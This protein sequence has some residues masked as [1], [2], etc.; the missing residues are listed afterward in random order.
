MMQLPVLPIDGRQSATAL[1]VARGTGRVLRRLGLVV[2]PEVG[3]PDG[4]RADL[5]AVGRRGDIWIVEI[6]SSVIDFQVDRKWPDYRN[7]CDRLHFAVSPDFP[8]EILPEDTGLIVA[9]NYD[10]ALIREAPDHRL[11]SHTRRAMT[12][13]IAR[14][15]AARLHQAIDPDTPFGDLD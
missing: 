15:A 9:D 14:I 10:G 8:V 7:H 5:V 4:R 1:A 11:T 6:K 12:L 13:L 3:L 2:V